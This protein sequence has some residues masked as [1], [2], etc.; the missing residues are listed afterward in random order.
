MAA[1]VAPPREYRGNESFFLDDPEKVWTVVEGCADLFCEPLHQGRI[2]GPR[3][4][5]FRV[6]KGQLLFGLKRT[7]P[8][9]D[10]RVSVVGTP[11]TRICE[12]ARGQVVDWLQGSYKDWAERS[13]EHWTALLGSCPPAE[14]APR[15]AAQ[16]TVDG[17][18]AVGQEEALV[19]TKQAVWARPGEGVRLLYKGLREY[20]WPEQ[21]YF[22]VYKESWGQLSADGRVRT[23]STGALASHG[24]LLPMLDW[25]HHF[26]MEV[27]VKESRRSVKEDRSRLRKRAESEKAVWDDSVQRLDTV[28]AKESERAAAERAA[29]PLLAASRLVGAAMQLEIKDHPYHSSPKR[30]AGRE[31]AVDLDRIAKASRCRMRAVTLQDGWW[32]QDSGPLVGTLKEGKSPVALLQPKPGRYEMVDPE[33]GQRTAV[34]KEVADRIESLAFMFYAPFPDKDLTPLD[35][36]KF[37]VFGAKNDIGMLLLMGAAG[38]ILGTMTPLATGVIFDTLIPGA[39]RQQMVQITFGLIFAAL[40]TALFNITRG[41]AM[42]RLEGRMD[43]SLQAAVWDRLMSLPVPFFRDF[44]AGELTERALAVNMIRTVMSGTLISSVL[45]TMFSVFNLILMFYINMNLALTAVVLVLIN[46]VITFLA[47]LRQMGMQRDL[48]T[49]RNGITGMLLQYLSGVAKLRVTGSE[50]R[51]FSR[52]AKNFSQL[53]G[54]SYRAGVVGNMLSVFNSTFP[55]LCSLV[56]FAAWAI[57]FAQPAGGGGEAVVGEGLSTGQFLAF[58]AAFGAFLAAVVEM[59]NTLIRVMKIIPM[60]EGV[61]PIIQAKPEVNAQMGDPGELMGDIEVGRVSFR[62]AKDGPAVLS[63]VSLKIN[64][65]EFVAIVGGSGSGK[66][67]LLRLLLGFE[68][69]E[70]GSLYFDGQDISGLDVRAVR[71]Q[72]GVVLQNTQMMAGD[73]FTN[74]VGANPHLTLE[75]AWEAARLA[76]MEEDI[77]EMPMGMHT[78]LSQG[79]GTLSGGQRQ[80]LAIARAVVN[81]PRILFF[82][83]ATSALDNRTQSVVGQSLAQLQATRVVIAHRLSTIVNADRI[84]VLDKGQVVESGTY[85]ELMDKKGSFAELAKRQ[86]A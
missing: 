23:A 39:E 65:G 26:F 71:R 12:Y 64:R 4:H 33:T 17:E 74:I 72:I 45:S 79:G 63:N 15:E 80:R 61:K 2:S 38:G 9:S 42:L 46:G 49:L 78:M 30:P 47:G 69:P 73:L 83:E 6:E 76:G 51:A 81:K 55:A 37:G 70:S 86:V 52:W 50:G 11:G 24:L 62:Y 36:L 53:K 29:D 43:A 67:T 32:V 20:E 59:S 48:M 77:Q 13:I 85:K 56:I 28:L 41:V 27:M 1:V 25:V 66:S 18:Q 14:M 22:P 75:R 84:F 68:Q 3:R 34:T 8:Q 19:S 35:F 16:L 5:L 40:A 10:I 31:A 7:T 60:F 21:V 57:H 82:D 54:I 58:N 44:T